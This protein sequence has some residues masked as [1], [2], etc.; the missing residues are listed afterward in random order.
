MGNWRTAISVSRYIIEF[1]FTR[2]SAPVICRHMRT[3]SRRIRF[4]RRAILLM[5]SLLVAAWIVSLFERVCVT[6]SSGEVF[7]NLGR[8]VIW[9]YSFDAYGPDG[10]RCSAGRSSLSFIPSAYT[11][12]LCL[13]QINFYMPRSVTITIPFWFLLLLTSLPIPLL[14]RRTARLP[15]HCRKCGYDLTG[16]ESG[17]CPECGTRSPIELQHIGTRQHS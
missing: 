11:L 9:Q 7:I 4:G 14:W 3:N 12:G 2:H 16:N 15:G 13:P 5:M 10:L 8:V 6:H 17:R 1:L